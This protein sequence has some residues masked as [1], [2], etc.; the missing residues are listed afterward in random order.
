MESL[1]TK[2]LRIKRLIVVNPNI[3]LNTQ[4]NMTNLYLRYL[5]K[6]FLICAQVFLFA[7]AFTKSWYSLIVLP[8]IFIN[9]KY[10]S[11]I[12]VHKK[13]QSN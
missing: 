6:W 11:Q 10:I 9:I 13:T 12:K 3:N 7:I 1:R 5:L 2:P 4:T 8:L